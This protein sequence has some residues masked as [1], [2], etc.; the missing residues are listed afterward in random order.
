VEVYLSLS[1]KERI[2]FETIVYILVEITTTVA[3]WWLDA[4]ISAAEASNQVQ[5]PY[6]R[7]MVLLLH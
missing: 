6:V 1:S 7:D 2:S 5:P 4:S 3:S